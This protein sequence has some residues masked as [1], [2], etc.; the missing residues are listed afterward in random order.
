MQRNNRIVKKSL[1]MTLV[2]L[3]GIGS[4]GFAE[5]PSAVLAFFDGN[6]RIFDETGFEKLDFRF[7]EPLGAGFRIETRQGSAE[8]QLLP[9]RTIMRLTSGT[10]FVINAIQGAGGATTN[11][12]TV[13]QGRVRTVVARSEGADYRFR[14]ATAVGGVR[15]TDFGIDVIPGEVDQLFVR[16]GAVE[17]TNLNTGQSLLLGA[18][19]L[20]NTFAPIFQAISLSAQQISELFSGLDF[21]ELQPQEVPGQVQEQA[22]TL[23]EDTEESGDEE[24]TT[25]STGTGDS[26]EP[27]PQTA[28]QQE[29]RTIEQA[30]NVIMDRLLEFLSLQ[31][32][33]VTINGITYGQAIFQPRFEFGNVRTQL[34]LPIIYTNDLFDRST[35]Y[36]GQGNDE[37]SFGTDQ[38]G[39]LNVI[40][41]IARD[42]ILKIKFLEIGNYRDPF[43]L[44]LG[45]IESM[46][47]GHGIL[48]NEYRNDADFPAV[49]RVGFNLGIN[50]ERFGFELLTNDLAEP[51]IF[52]TRVL[53]R[54]FGRVFPVG[55]ALSA[56]ADI[57][58]ARELK[59][60]ND[61]NS[62]AD[63]DEASQQALFQQS[64]IA[65]PIFT[66]F[67][68]DLD[69]PIVETGFLSLVLFGDFGIMI[70]Y[71]RNDADIGG[72][73]VRAGYRVDSLL[74]GL[75]LRNYGIQTGIFGNIAIIDYR[76]E[77]QYY[78]GSFIPNFYNQPYDRI[79]SER[80]IEVLENLANP[81][82]ATMESNRAGIFGTGR[83][84]IL[85]NLN[86]NIGYRW[87]W[88][89][90]AAG[91][92]NVS[93]DDYFHIGV[94]I[95]KGLLPLG[96]YG[97][98]QYDRIRFRDVFTSSDFTLFDENAVVSGS[99]GI[100]LSPIMDLHLNIGTAVVRDSN[101]VVQY[102][103]NGRPKFGPTV[104]LET[105][106]GF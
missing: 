89:I 86:A 91:S 21:I 28:E 98:V 69:I 51:E 42:L 20:A 50:T 31:V 101:G 92:A 32:G 85:P 90:G 104:T 70:P 65:D 36:K 16:S 73:T 52:G 82:N 103:D 26:T 23:A 9:N 100:E 19:Q 57:N 10:T 61:A 62:F 37:W 72:Q 78:N 35:W 80:V 43:F 47:L 71:V 79:R 95:Q 55:V 97:S 81:N 41:D 59:A 44:K 6:I 33:S 14:T 17:F 105:R 75:S 39:T 3:L 40:T 64:A 74:D 12:F 30:E 60:V 87:P 29:R 18:G 93:A 8:L 83:V 1:I 63:I 24:G 58:P 76:L 102:K 54:P 34:Y 106:I 84:R 88:V 4:L 22:Q 49:R 56:A 2:L 15:G 25:Q 11:D 66:N 45:N 5:T 7:G 68:V 48:I 96:I 38:D 94:D 13:Q 53:W 99:L 46:T 67:A 77:F 27:I